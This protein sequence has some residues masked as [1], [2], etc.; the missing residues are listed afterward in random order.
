MPINYDRE[1]QQVYEQVDNANSKLFA[2]WCEYTV[3]TWEWWLQLLLTILPWVLW[4]KLRKVDSTDRL[5]YSGLFVII[6]TCWLDFLGVTLGLWYYKHK[7]I[8]LLPSYLPWDFCIFPV[9]VMLML[10]YKQ[11]V[12]PF[13][14]ALFF[15]GFAAFVGEPL[16]IWLD[17][18]EPVKWETYYSFP[19][20]ILIYLVAYWISKRDQFN[21][22]Q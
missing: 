15:G 20:Y 19:I 4:L 22:F 12:H 8:P 6:I 3:F 18:Y 11:N 17:L 7:L 2:L 13:I 16:F 10:Q 9:I 14:K 5:L 21:A 1:V